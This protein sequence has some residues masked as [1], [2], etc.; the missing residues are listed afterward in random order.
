[1]HWLAVSA[2]SATLARGA[3]LRAPA[4]A[5]VEAPRIEAGLPPILAP[6]AIEAPASAILDEA[7]AALR[8]P[9]GATDVLG[10]LE[11]LRRLE[12]VDAREDLRLAERDRTRGLIGHAQH[13]IDIRLREL[14]LA[15]FHGP[16]DEDSLVSMARLLPLGREEM[17]QEAASI[18]QQQRSLP[19]RALDALEPAL[20][21][22]RPAVREEAADL[23][24]LHPD[25]EPVARARAAAAEPAWD[26]IYDLTKGA[27]HIPP[28]V[29]HQAVLAAARRHGAEFGWSEGEV[30]AAFEAFLRRAAEYAQT[31]RR[32]YKALSR[33]F[34]GGPD[35]P[36]PRASFDAALKNPRDLLAADLRLK[37]ET[38]AALREELP[39][40]MS[41]AGRKAGA[42]IA[43]ALIVGSLSGHPTD[44]SDI[45]LILVTEIGGRLG[46]A[47]WELRPELAA[48]LRRRG[49]PMRYIHA[50]SAVPPGSLAFR[51]AML[52]GAV[53]IPAAP[54]AAP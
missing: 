26:E 52:G 50:I 1:M 30:G 43:G 47:M 36:D 46:E 34:R 19:P 48:A 4:Q 54:D 42:R 12:A 5:P 16:L 20:D 18:L 15:G 7:A 6:T 39:A 21:D 29:T 24:A 13:R 51:R 31:P 28:S 38:L 14:A 23:L 22:P 53:Y 41:R 10:T 3:S 27:V 11:L 45:D 35:I 25:R 32:L 40:L 37:E 44:D 8:A 9:A 33:A 2:V 17:R 49:M